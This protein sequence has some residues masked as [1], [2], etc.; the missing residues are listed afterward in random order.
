M[1]MSFSP[2]DSLLRYF[3]LPTTVVNLTMLVL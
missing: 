1:D 3:L 2:I